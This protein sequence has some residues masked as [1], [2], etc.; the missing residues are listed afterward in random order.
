MPMIDVYS[1]EGLVAEVDR[2]GLAEE[3]TTALLRAEHAPDAEVY[4]HNTAAYLH[5]LPPSAVHTAATDQARVV[6]V[7][8]ITPPGGLDRDGQR[9]FV[10]EATGIVAKYAAGAPTWVILTEAAE[11]GWGIGG[12][13]LGKAEFAALRPR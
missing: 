11:G 5:T 8:V 13:A 1:P 2:R 10:A 4:R 7:Q 9:Q 3:L 12:R 6:R